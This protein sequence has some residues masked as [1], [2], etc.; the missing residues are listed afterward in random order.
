M[1]ASRAAAI[2][3]ADVDEGGGEVGEDGEEGADDAEELEFISAA[4]FL[5]LTKCPGQARAETQQRS[6]REALWN[7]RGN[8]VNSTTHTRGFVSQ[9]KP[10]AL[11]I[12]SH[13]L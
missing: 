2:A 7:Q 9:P 1:A 12:E 10:R 3:E 13:S 5:Q 8:L 4:V 11:L 6:V